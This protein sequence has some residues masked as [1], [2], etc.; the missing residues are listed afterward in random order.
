MAAVQIGPV[1]KRDVKRASVMLEHKEEFATI[2]AFDVKIEK[3]AAE[4]A[5]NVGVRI[6]SADIIY[7]LFDAWTAYLEQLAERRREETKAEAVF[8][9][10]FKVLPDSI[11]HAQDPIILGV[12]ITKGQ[13]RVGTPLVVP[14]RDML[15]IGMVQSIE[16]GRNEVQKAKAG[17]EVA[18][19][20]KTMPGMGNVVGHRHFFEGDEVVSRISRGSIDVLKAHYM[21]EMSKDDWK[22]VIKLKELLKIN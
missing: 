6:F 7:H 17:E 2:L 5:E 9:C 16:L 21:K 22:V 10:R 13:L 11:F 19:K 4:M 14:S 12:S 1:H 3:E 8:P 15:L 20:L 18:I